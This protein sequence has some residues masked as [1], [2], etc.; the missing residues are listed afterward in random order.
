MMV[1]YKIFDLMSLESMFQVN[2]IIKSQDSIRKIKIIASK[3][4]HT[5]F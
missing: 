4:E 3:H 1:R 2:R 5:D